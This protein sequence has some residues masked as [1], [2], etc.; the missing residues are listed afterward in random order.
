MTI[1]KRDGREVSFDVNRITEAVKKAIRAV[2]G[3][4]TAQSKL[5]AENI[6]CEIENE[7]SKQGRVFNVEQ[8][9]DMV[10]NKLMSSDRKDVAKAYITYR[11]ERTREREKTSSLMQQIGEKLLATNVQNQNA[12][13]DERS[14]GGRMGE[15]RSI[16]V[17]Q[18]ALTNLVSPMARKH[19]EDNEIYEHDLDAYAV[20]LHNCLTSPLDRLLSEGFVTRQTTVRPAGSIKSAMQLVAVIFQLQSL[21]QFGG[22][23]ASHLDWTMVPYVRKSFAKHFKVGMKFIAGKP[24]YEIADKTRSITDPLYC[25]E[26]EVYRYAIEQ[27]NEEVKQATEAMFHNLKNML[28]RP[29]S[30]AGNIAA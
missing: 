14:F 1:I 17:K 30:N 29:C 23:A 2:D 4:L 10:E 27:T 24:D 26:P 3:R 16:V 25:N 15:A 6:A 13:V 7:C 21:C 18:Y 20:G 9:Q 5:L 8:I 19:H 22:V 28:G 11:S 12:N